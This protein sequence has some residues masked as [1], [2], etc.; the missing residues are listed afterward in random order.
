M[1]RAH[2]AFNLGQFVPEAYQ[3][4][5]ALFGDIGALAMMGFDDVFKPSRLAALCLEV[6]FETITSLLQILDP[7]I[8][9]PFQRVKQHPDGR[10]RATDDEPEPGR[11]VIGH[12]VLP[13]RRAVLSYGPH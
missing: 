7:F 5:L 6:T 11:R 13:R 10:K 8:A 2:P 4:R 12:R 3:F 1:T 9:A